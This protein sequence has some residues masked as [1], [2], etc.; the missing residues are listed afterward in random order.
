MILRLALIQGPTHLR[1]SCITAELQHRHNIVREL[2][3]WFIF[4]LKVRSRVVPLPSTTSMRGTREVLSVERG[5]GCPYPDRRQ[6]VA[7]LR[8]GVG[9]KY[10]NTV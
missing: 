8:H 5:V 6:R 3:E 4:S 9:A 2:H 10:P 1:I 7:V